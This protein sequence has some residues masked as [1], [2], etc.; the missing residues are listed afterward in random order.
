MNKFAFSCLVLCLVC[1]Y[2]INTISACESSD[3]TGTKLTAAATVSINSNGI[4]SIPAFSLDKPAIIAA[5]VLTKG[6]FSYEPVLAYSLE[7]KPWFIDN[8]LRYKIIDRPRFM[9]RT[10]FNASTFFSVYKLTDRNILQ[11]ERYF[12]LELTG[13]WKITPDNLLNIAYWSD[14]GMEKGTISGHFFTITA[15]RTGID[16]GRW[17]SLSAAL[18]VFYINY[19]GKNDG[20]FLC[21]KLSASISETPFAAFFQ[22]TQA[23]SSNIDPFPGFR[24][25]LGLSYTF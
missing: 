23:I 4:A 12:A 13:I 1:C 25:N 15:E 16:I 5:L 22:A 7:L 2:F 18:Q 11:G 20:F 24:W 14:N 9:L 19:S 10:G 21:P 6:R 17:I 3:T 8:W